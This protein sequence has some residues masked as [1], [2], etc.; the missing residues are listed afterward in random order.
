[1]II[2]S[3]PVIA[4]GGGAVATPKRVEIYQSWGVSP[5][6]KGVQAPQPPGNSSRAGMK[7]SG[8]LA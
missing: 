7:R 4:R 2:R 3:K 8:L 1:V 6:A 5:R